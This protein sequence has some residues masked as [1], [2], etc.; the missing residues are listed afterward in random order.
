M[1]DLRRTSGTLASAGVRFV[2]SGLGGGLRTVLYDEVGGAAGVATALDQFYPKVLADPALSPF[3]DGVNIELL[4]KRIGSFMAMA[5]GGPS[6][7]R[8]PT[9][10]D[11][12]NRMS[13]DDK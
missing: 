7:Y 13:I 3:F 12:H 9:L 11:V 2:F 5:L 6:D 4:K 1:F 10:R 8:G